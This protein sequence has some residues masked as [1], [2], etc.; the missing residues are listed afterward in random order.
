MPALSHAAEM[1]TG[2]SY[3]EVV[4]REEKNV[5]P[6]TEIEARPV[7]VP[8]VEGKQLSSSAM[9]QTLLCKICC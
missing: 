2:S 8:V 4:L 1:P 6:V 5:A 9:K 7:I 3:E